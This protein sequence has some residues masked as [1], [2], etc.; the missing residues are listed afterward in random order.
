LSFVV[1]KFEGAAEKGPGQP[2][3]EKPP[4]PHWY[5][6][7]CH[8]WPRILLQGWAANKTFFG[9]LRFRSQISKTLARRGMI[10]CN[11]K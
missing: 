3:Q 8:V 11:G 6:A 4:L 9:D 10:F 7:A 2:N 1:K 5:G